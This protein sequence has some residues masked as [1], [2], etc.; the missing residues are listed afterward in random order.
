MPSEESEEKD[1]KT[2][3]ELD[4]LY[5]GLRVLLPGVQVMFGFLLAAVFAQGFAKTT[6][7]Q[8]IAFY[9]AL[10]S[11]AVS[12]IMLMAPSV[13]H[14]MLFPHE[15]PEAL[16]RRASRYMLIGTLFVGTALTSGIYMVLD[17]L[18]G[19]ALAIAT[20]VTVGITL[21]AVWYLVPYLHGSSE[22]HSGK[23]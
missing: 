12:A 1:Q 22:R 17:Y 3:D 9:I 13:H 8:R 10:V 20:S 19:P 16:L 7:P 6:D 14:R 4:Q 15:D 23:G 2:A 5:Q 21:G 11:V 18:F